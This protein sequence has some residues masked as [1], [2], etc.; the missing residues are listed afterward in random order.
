MDCAYGHAH[1]PAGG[2][3]VGNEDPGGDDLTVGFEDD[4]LG[5]ALQVVG[6]E[7]AQVRVD[8]RVERLPPPITDCARRGGRARSV[9]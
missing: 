1:D 7:V 9:D 2:V 4:D 5:A 3:V 8:A 6:D